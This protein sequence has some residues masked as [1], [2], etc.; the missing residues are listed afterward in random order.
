VRPFPYW[1]FKEIKLP[2]LK[3]VKPTLDGPR[4]ELRLAILEVEAEEVDASKA[5][6]EAD[7]ASA[8]LRTAKLAHGVAVDALDAARSAR[9]PLADRLAAACT[10]NERWEI[11]EEHEA[12]KRRPAITVD[13]LKRMRQEIEAAYDAVTVARNALE[14]AEDR[15]RPA[16]SALRRAKDRRERAV[17]E[18]VRPE[19]GRLM[20]EC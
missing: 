2:A 3:I 19:I 5:Q 1:H 16:L 4:E 13:D 9:V 8:R 17:G 14:L 20:R 18:V 6:A 15:A 7:Q 12:A 11:V 10:D